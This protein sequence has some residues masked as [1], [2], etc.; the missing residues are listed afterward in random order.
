LRAVDDSSR[1]APAAGPSR[2]NR[3]RWT[4]P[5]RRLHSLIFCTYPE[6]TPATDDPPPRHGSCTGG[7]PLASPAVDERLLCQAAYTSTSCAETS[8]EET[9]C[10]EKM[11]RL[12]AAGPVANGLQNG[13]SRQRRLPEPTG[14]R[15][16]CE[17][18]YSN[19]L[20]SRRSSPANRFQSLG[21]IVGPRCNR[22]AG[23]GR[24][25]QASNCISLHG[26]TC[27][28]HGRLY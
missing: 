13:R 20:M 2:W 14:R 19:C 12:G 7:S 10:A 1:P 5:T 6:S 21:P 8:C 22:R 9:S 3:N 27:K 17:K 28:L 11:R 18:I 4:W 26:F 24:R 23:G 16:D 25:A 15:W